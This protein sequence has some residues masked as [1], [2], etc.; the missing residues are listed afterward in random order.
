MNWKTTL[1]GIALIASGIVTC[2]NG[3]LQE[4]ITQIVGGIG[5]IAAKDFNK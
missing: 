1:S 3:H 2:I 4:G 5:L